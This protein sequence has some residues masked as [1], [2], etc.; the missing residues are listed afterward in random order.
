M[1]YPRNLTKLLIKLHHFY[2]YYLMM[3]KQTGGG[4]RAK[5]NNKKAYKK[6]ITIQ[7]IVKTIENKAFWLCTKNFASRPLSVSDT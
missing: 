4:K 3:I 2:V 5:K 6:H 7:I 1:L